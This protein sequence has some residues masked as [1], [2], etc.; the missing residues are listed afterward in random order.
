MSSV[1]GVEVNHNVQSKLEL[2]GKLLVDLMKQ[3]K[4]C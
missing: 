3:V 2:K 4:E 1:Y